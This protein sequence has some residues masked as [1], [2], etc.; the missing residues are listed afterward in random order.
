[1]QLCATL[2]AQE[3]H[4]TRRRRAAAQWL[5]R[6]R[7]PIVHCKHFFSRRNEKLRVEEERRRGGST[8]FP[9]GWQR[10]SILRRLSCCSS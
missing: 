3:Q 5:D 6:L 1:M 8:R 7:P 4:I 9:G 2:L 10:F